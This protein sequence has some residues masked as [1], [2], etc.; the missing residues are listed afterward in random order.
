MFVLKRAEKTGWLYGNNNY[1]D[2][3][4]PLITPAAAAALVLANCSMEV[5]LIVSSGGLMKMN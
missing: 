4:L 2:L 1:Y 3:R 5:R